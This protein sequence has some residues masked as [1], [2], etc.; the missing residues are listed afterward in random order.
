MAFD[1][2]DIV[3]T[4]VKIAFVLAITLSITPVMVWVERRGSALIQDRPGPNRVGPFGLL[5]SLADALKFILKEDVLPA[6]AHRWLYTLAPVFGLIPAVVTISV[7]PFARSFVIPEMNVFGR[8]WF[9]GGRIFEPIIADVNIGILLIFALAS[10]GVYGMALAGWSSNNK[11]SLFGG[12]RASAQM[13]SYELALT[14]AAIGALMGAGSLRLTEVVYRQTGYFVLFG[15]DWLRIPAWNI[16]PMFLGFIVF[17]VATFAETN[18]LP[19]DFAEAEAE[20]VAG[21]HTEYSSMKFAMFFMAEYMAMG[22]ISALTA[23][24]FLGGWDIPWYDEPATFVGF[25]LSGLAFLIK[26]SFLLFVFVWV[27]WTLPRLKY[28]Y[29]MKIGWK[30]FLPMAILNILIVAILIAFRWI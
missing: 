15:I 29:L 16:F 11:Y 10:L 19:F 25:L 14:L 6:Q 7:V 30:V 5:Q 1:T 8:T 9:E 22:T 20:L 13:I 21:Y 17:Y 2:T 18:R 24:L 23:T 27:R 26:V 4:V 3:L 12:I 28:D